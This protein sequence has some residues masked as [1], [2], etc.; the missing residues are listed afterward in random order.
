M[1]YTDKIKHVPPREVE[2][3]LVRRE[4]HA[5]AL[6][7]TPYNEFHVKGKFNTVCLGCPL[8]SGTLVCLLSYSTWLVQIRPSWCPLCHCAYVHKRT[9]RKEPRRIVSCDIWINCSKREIG[10]CWMRMEMFVVLICLHCKHKAQVVS[11][12]SILFITDLL[13]RVNSHWN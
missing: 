8:T 1:L 4:I 13:Q 6:C 2:V 9:K 3:S 11:D 10:E 7:I 12:A 5:R